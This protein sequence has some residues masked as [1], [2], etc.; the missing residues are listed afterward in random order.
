MDSTLGPGFFSHR[1][2]IP[3]YGVYLFNRI[4]GGV[5][6]LLARCGAFDCS[7]CHCLRSAGHFLDACGPL[8]DGAA[9]DSERSAASLMWLRTSS[10]EALVS[11][12]RAA[13]FSDV[14]EISMATF[15]ISSTVSAWAEIMFAGNQP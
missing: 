14:E 5:S 3:D 11:W 8:F 1:P 10:M 9:F 13:R 4:R 7:F 15:C 2:E 6:G 12:E